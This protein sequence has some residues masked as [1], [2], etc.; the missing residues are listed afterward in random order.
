MRY[1]STRS[2]HP[3]V[4]STQA[5]NLGMVPA[6]GL[7]V[8]ETTPPLD[9]P[10]A[11]GKTYEE[12]A[13]RV[14]T[15]LLDDFSGGELALCVK[16][17][18]GTAAFACSDVVALPQLDHRRFILELFHGPTA[19]FKDVA[20][21]IMPQFMNV[22][23]TKLGDR[24]HTVILV[25]T[26]GDTGKAAL[27]GFRDREGISIVVFYPHSGVSQIQRLQMATTEGRN[28]HVV[29][30]KGNFDDCQTAVKNIFGNPESNHHAAERG[31]AF[32]SANSI[33]WGRLCP[34]IVYYVKAYLSLVERAVIRLD[35]PVDFCVPTGNFGNLLAGYYA[36]KMGL[37]IR[38]LICAS[39]KNKILADFFSTGVYDRNRVFY[40]TMSPSMDILISSNLERFVFEMAGRDAALVQRWYDDLARTGRFAVDARTKAAMDR[41]VVPGWV[42]EAQVTAAI[43][44]VYAKTGYLLDTHTAVAVAVSDQIGHDEIPT[45][46]AA[47]ASPY[48]FSPD[49]LRALGGSPSDDEFEAVK[50]LHETTS[51][52][53]HRAVACLR[54]KPIRHTAVIEIGEMARTVAGIIDGIP[55]A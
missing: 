21:Q 45:I 53:V 37:P 52:P 16:Q 2:N 5:I 43:G 34:Q 48:K 11:L 51:V 20:L 19:A 6:G 26:S 49:V 17:G 54:D 38:R 50:K 40:R 28:T 41:V 33:N 3:P 9:W 27:E 31:C 47:T 10:G 24:A 29:A 44:S 14:L 36:M 8:P 42:D 35:E 55:R 25:A 12:T 18:Y 13:M 46:I 22:A 4:S 1:I 15:P 7:F 32:S 30:V 39:N 23:K